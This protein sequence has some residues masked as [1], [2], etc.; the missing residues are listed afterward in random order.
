MHTVRQ[1]RATC[2]RPRSLV[3]RAGRRV[4]D[5][6]SRRSGSDEENRRRS[7]TSRDFGSTPQ[8]YT[9]GSG[10]R[11]QDDRAAA[12]NVKP[13]PSTLR[14]RSVDYSSRRPGNDDENARRGISR[15]FSSPTSS[16]SST[17]RN[18]TRRRQSADYASPPPAPT[19]SSVYNPATQTPPRRSSSRPR[20]IPKRRSA[21]YASR[22]SGSQEENQRRSG[23]Y[24][25]PAQRSASSPS[26]QDSGYSSTEEY[27]GSTTYEFSA[28]AS[29][30]PSTPARRSS[31][32]PRII[33]KRRSTD[34]PSRRPGNQE[35]NQR[36]SGDF[37]SPTPA[38]RR[39]ASQRVTPQPRAEPPYRGDTPALSNEV[40]R[41][42]SSRPRVVPKRRSTDYPSRRPGNQEENIRRSRDYESPMSRA[43]TDSQQR[44]APV[45]VDPPRTPVRRRSSTDYGSRR[46]G[47]DQENTRRRSSGDFVP[48]SRD[49]TA[50][51]RDEPPRRAS[52]QPRRRVSVDYASR[53]NNTQEENQRR[54]SVDM[55][56]GDVREPA[57]EGP[58][59]SVSARRNANNA[60][61]PTYADPA[62]SS[63]ATATDDDADEPIRK[64][65]VEPS[66]RRSFVPAAESEY[67]PP[68]Y[69][70]PPPPLPYNRAFT[71]W[72]RIIALNVPSSTF[73]LLSLIAVDFSTGFDLT[74]IAVRYGGP[75]APPLSVASFWLASVGLTGIISTLLTSIVSPEAYVLKSTCPDCGATVRGNFGGVLGK[76]GN[77]E[78]ATLECDNCM[79]DLRFDLEGRKVVLQRDS[80]SKK[81]EALERGRQQALRVARSQAADAQ[82]E[83]RKYMDGNK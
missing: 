35:E 76:R 69:E 27:D 66:R 52:V 44:Q 57:K 71:D 41:R 3:V 49:G 33:P 13:S 20:I 58:P 78:S 70:E 11:H 77:R 56:S 40:P 36:R 43:D 82:A 17:A 25:S 1:G 30:A 34:Y 72:P 31:S 62:P 61:P 4:S 51:P 75:G 32:R 46:A 54:R 23:N 2:A 53:R 28:P 83:A 9:N 67:T 60:S 63:W 64:V 19:A 21:D 15:D 26:S 50:P 65:T 48:L 24:S 12:S 39:S 45:R 7:R 5:Y 42:S 8:N 47:L 10:P 80:G 59:R 16:R 79:A 22:R 74:R 29:A 55:I 38:R 73:V 81:A 37:Q 6:A 14:R 68:G 18:D